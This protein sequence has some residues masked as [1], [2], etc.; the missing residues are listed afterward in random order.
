[1]ETAPTFRRVAHPS[2]IVV[3][4]IVRGFAVG[5]TM[6]MAVG[7]SL[8]LLVVIV[9]VVWGAP[10]GAAA[11]AVAGTFYGTR[12]GIVVAVSV[13]RGKIDPNGDDWPAQ[14]T[15]TAMRTVYGFALVVFLGVLAGMRSSVAGWGLS[16]V[17]FFPVVLWIVDK[18]GVPTWG[19]LFWG[20]GDS[21]N[22]RKLRRAAAKLKLKT[23]RHKRDLRPNGP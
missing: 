22:Q 13:W 17:M 9:G 16:L 3:I 23:E 19:S 20:E 1:M 12:I 18:T 10:I 4:W 6:G 11:G 5:L 21:W 8:G 2:E 15:K 7:G 14:S